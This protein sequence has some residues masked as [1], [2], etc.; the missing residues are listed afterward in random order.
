MNEEI[1]INSQIEEKPGAEGKGPSA[2][3]RGKKEANIMT[4]PE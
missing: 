2:K 3:S 1:T 4:I